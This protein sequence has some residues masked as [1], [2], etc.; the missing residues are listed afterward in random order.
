MMLVALMYILGAIGALVCL[1]AIAL[2]IYG[3]RQ[4]IGG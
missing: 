4:W 3:V 1:A 2:I